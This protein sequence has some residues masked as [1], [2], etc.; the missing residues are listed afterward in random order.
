MFTYRWLQTCCIRQM[1]EMLV[2]AFAKKR[3]YLPTYAA[4]HIVVD[5]S[6]NDSRGKFAAVR[7]LVHKVTGIAYAGKFIRKRRRSMDQRQEI[8]HEV[9][10]LMMSDKAGKI[11]KLLEVYETPTEMAL[12]LELAAGGE[13]QRVVDLQDGL[14]EVEAI[15]FM[16]QVLEALVFLHNRNIAH[17]DLKPQNMLLTRDYPDTDIVLCDFGISRVIQDGVEVREILGTPDYVAPEVLSYEP[18]SLSTDMWSVGVLAYVLLSG[19]SPFAGDTKQQTFCNISQCALTFP[20]ELFEGVSPA[21][22][23]FIQSTLVVDPSCRLSAEE[24]LSH[25]WLSGV[26]LSTRE[27]IPYLC[28]ACA[29]CGT[30][31]SCHHD[32]SSSPVVEITHDRGIIC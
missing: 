5:V 26:A 31:G 3:S 10:V 18:I 9:A 12:V 20:P 8:L 4:F 25:P 15:T 6:K 14:E 2:L 23:H 29:K 21:A 27:P 16:K 22:I 19:Y 30:S 7:R 24:C 17:L 28:L 32:I 1:L 13:L 11:V